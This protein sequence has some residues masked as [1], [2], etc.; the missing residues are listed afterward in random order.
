MRRRFFLI[1][2]PG[3]GVF[4]APLVDEVVRALLS[5]GAAVE[6]TTA[7]SLKDATLAAREAAGS[8]R[9]DAVV[10]AGGDGT[11]RHVASALIGTDTPLGIIPVGT[12][13]VLAHEIGLPA[14]PAAVASTL[15]EGPISTVACAEANGETFLLMVGAGFDARVLSSLDQRLKSRVGKMA[16]AGPLLGALVRPADTLDVTIDGQ[17]RTASWVVI[18]N[19]R[20]YGGR[21]VLAPHAGI[22]ERGLEAILF[23]S[24][25]RTV[26]L[27]QLMSLAA[28]RQA[29]EL[30]EQNGA[31]PR[32]EEDGLEPALQNAGVRR[33]HEAAAVVARVG[34][35]DPARGAMLAVDGD[36]EGVGGADQGA[37]QRPGVR[38]LADAALEALVER[39]QHA[40]IEAGTDH[41]Q[42]GLAVGLG[43]GDRG[44]RPF[45]QRGGDGR[46][47]RG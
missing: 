30:A 38:H 2:N 16:Y 1:A 22:L 17:H 32:L 24:R 35:H 26:L 46:G 19:A 43:A 23:K 4:G 45:E 39:G 40:G 21:F 10:A 6:R 12:G 15:L 18:A 44:N 5:R 3:A 14:T 11:I 28:G 7:A 27:G 33:Q 25:S 31:A 29:H 13:N 47:C 34:D 36:V 41:E 8:G 37:E 20:H 42:E 9:Y